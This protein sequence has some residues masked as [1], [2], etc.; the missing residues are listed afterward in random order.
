MQCFCGVTHASPE[1]AAA[2]HA[3]RLNRVDAH[4]ALSDMGAI[5]VLYRK[6]EYQATQNTDGTYTITLKSGEEKTVKASQV[7]TL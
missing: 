7:K 2:A 3:P 4:I 6:K 5:D 1:A